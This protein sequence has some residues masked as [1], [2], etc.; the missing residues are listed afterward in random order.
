MTDRKQYNNLVEMVKNWMQNSPARVLPINSS[1]RKADVEANR[2]LIEHSIVLVS[3]PQ[4]YELIFWVGG[5]VGSVYITGEFSTATE[6]ISFGLRFQQ[7]YNEVGRSDL[8]PNQVASLYQECGSWVTPG[9]IEDF[10]DSYNIWKFLWD[11]F[12]TRRNATTYIDV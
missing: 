12:A 4:T 1:R 10:Q 3:N 5:G 8:N 6:A 9:T 11:N 2:F 7:I